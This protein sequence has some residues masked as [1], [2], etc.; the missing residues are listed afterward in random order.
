M[1]RKINYVAGGMLIAILLCLC[2]GCDQ[3]ATPNAEYGFEGP[4]RHVIAFT[5]SSCVQCQKDKPQLRE[6]AKQVSVTEI[7]VDAHPE[8]AR[9]YGVSRLP[10]YVALENG[11]V[12]ERTESLSLLLVTLKATWWIVSFVFF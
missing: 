9:K 8:I 6:L 11:N 3:A 5:N 4:G 7:D 10:T 2:G 1:N 12:M